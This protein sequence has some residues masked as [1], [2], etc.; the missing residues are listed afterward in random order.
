VGALALGEVCQKLESAGNAADAAACSALALALSNE[1]PSLAR[2]IRNAVDA[3]E[4][5]ANPLTRS[6]GEP[7]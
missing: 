2:R 3:A 7:T 6:H 4:L 1:F 5:A